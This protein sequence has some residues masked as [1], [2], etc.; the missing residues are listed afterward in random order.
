MGAPDKS[1]IED[2]QCRDHQRL[3][4]LADRDLQCDCGLEHPRDGAQ[5]W[6]ATC[7]AGWIR[8]STTAFGPNSNNRRAASAEDRPA[9]TGALVTVG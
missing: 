4:A 7:A 6:R 1:N 9:G 2:Q 5:K 8:S 3:K